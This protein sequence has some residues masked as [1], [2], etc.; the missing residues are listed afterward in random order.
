MI[1]YSAAEWRLLASTCADE[2][3]KSDEKQTLG[4]NE[5]VSCRWG[6]FLIPRDVASVDDGARWQHDRKQISGNCN[7]NG[8]CTTS[9]VKVEHAANYRDATGEYMLKQ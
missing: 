7:G 5:T 2:L 8:N 4:A 6:P 9:R 1:P 3:V